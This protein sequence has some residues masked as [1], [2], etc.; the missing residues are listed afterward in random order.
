V[1]ESIKT[2]AVTLHSRNHTTEYKHC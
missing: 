2:Y 1:T